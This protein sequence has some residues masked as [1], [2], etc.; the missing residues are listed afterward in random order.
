MGMRKN[1]QRVLKVCMSDMG[2]GR[3]LWR[4]IVGVL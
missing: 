4:K 3:A 2:A 1:M